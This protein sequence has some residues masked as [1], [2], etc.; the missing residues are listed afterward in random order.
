MYLFSNHYHNRNIAASNKYQSKFKAKRGAMGF[1]CFEHLYELLRIHKNDHGIIYTVSPCDDGTQTYCANR[2]FLHSLKIVKRWT[3]FDLYDFECKDS[4]NFLL[5]Y[6]EMHRKLCDSMFDEVRLALVECASLRV[7]EKLLRDPCSAVRIAIAK[8]YGKEFQDTLVHDN[9][10]QVILS[11]LEQGL[12]LDQF[13]DS[14]NTD[15]LIALARQGYALDKLLYHS[16]KFVSFEAA[17]YFFGHLQNGVYICEYPGFNV[18]IYF[19]P[20]D[21]AVMQNLCVDSH[22][23]L[24]MALNGIELN[25]FVDDECF[26]VRIAARRYRNTW[27]DRIYLKFIEV[28]HGKKN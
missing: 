27:F 10:S 22:M 28:F 7:V 26:D 21:E 19:D 8:R 25:R 9:N 15:Y 24:A 18:P 17:Y 2:V 13:V 4:H 6:K 1:E 20:Q 14:V 5:K 11:L 16:D 3:L 23:R 12:K